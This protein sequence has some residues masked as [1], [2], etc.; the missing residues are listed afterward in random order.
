MKKIFICIFLIAFI[1]SGCVQT[2]DPNSPYN[3]VYRTI[4]VDSRL[5]KNSINYIR[6]VF[7]KWSISTGTNY[8]MVTFKVI[9]DVSGKFD[10]QKQTK[11]CDVYVLK[12]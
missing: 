10:S 8:I 3:Q 12:E 6:K 2:F 11:F 4:C 7:E 9:F 1:I 5:D